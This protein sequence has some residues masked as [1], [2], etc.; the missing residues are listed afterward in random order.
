[1]TEDILQG[2][3]RVYIV[4]SPLLNNRTIRTLLS[5]GLGELQLHPLRFSRPILKIIVHGQVVSLFL[6]TLQTDRVRRSDPSIPAEAPLVVV[7]RSDSKRWLSSVD[8]NAAK[9]GLRF[10]ISERAGD[11]TST[12]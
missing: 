6:P 7:A 4:N 3:I 10:G 8:A 12:Y 11:A 2:N 5:L 1:M 9:L